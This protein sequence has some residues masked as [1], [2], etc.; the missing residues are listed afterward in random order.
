[1][2]SILVPSFDR[3]ETIPETLQSL[4]SQ[5]YQNWECLVVD[6]GSTDGTLE[7]A[8]RFAER[9]S[10]IRVL[11]RSRGPKGA[12]T[13]RNIGVEESR[14][15]YV[16]FLDSDDVIAPWC[17]EQRV[18]AFAKAGDVD[19]VVFPALMFRK[20][21]G[22]EDFFW[23]VITTDSDLMRFLKLDSPWQGTGPMWRRESFIRVGGWAEELECW[24]DV[25][26]AIRGFERR[27][28]YSTRYDLRPDLYL[29]RGDGNSISSRAM[30]SPQ[31]LA[32]KRQVLERA[33]RLMKTS[34]DHRIAP[35]VKTLATAVI[36]DHARGREPRRAVE[37]AWELRKRGVYSSKDL[38][39]VLLGIASHGR[40]V[41]RLPGSQAIRETVARRFGSSSTIGQVRYSS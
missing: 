18:E 29:R 37:L 8:R 15:D 5:T 36:V 33:L 34:E 10:R 41:N 27:V 16:L 31:K 6:D 30:Q 12:C 7:I 17:L 35:G 2:V 24:Q 19:F 26:L 23:N 32:S 13:C 28:S 39:L 1:M 40:G 25:E 3:A 21:P 4:L 14:G 22:D 38:I 11:E 20:I 9:D